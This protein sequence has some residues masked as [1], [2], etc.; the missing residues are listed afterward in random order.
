[1]PTKTKDVKHVSEADRLL[2]EALLKL[3]VKSGVSN[4][5]WA[6]SMGI[7]TANVH[8]TYLISGKRGLTFRKACQLA[9]AAGVDLGEIQKMVQYEKPCR[10]KKR[11]ANPDY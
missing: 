10:L 4:T 11:R 3:A 5:E 9:T 6:R 7:D 1:M 2:G 8:L